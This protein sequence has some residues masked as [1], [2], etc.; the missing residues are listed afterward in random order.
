MPM[1]F[2]LWVL[3]GRWGF[4]VKCSSSILRPAYPKMT[5]WK[6]NIPIND[7]GNHSTTAGMPTETCITINNQ[8]SASLRIVFPTPILW[9]DRKLKV[10]TVIYWLCETIAI[11]SLQE[12][13]F[14]GERNNDVDDNHGR[15]KAMF[16]WCNFRFILLLFF[17]F[18]CLDFAFKVLINE[19]GKKI[20]CR[21]RTLYHILFCSVLL[22]VSLCVSVS[23]CLSACLTLC[24][25]VSC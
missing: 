6:N 25:A 10:L 5:A 11:M 20:G 4:K 14:S 16:F 17:A 22:K 23:V 8:T 1:T 2:S 9:P 3:G 24:F 12:I 7:F 21:H 13:S 18:T 19:I 15:N